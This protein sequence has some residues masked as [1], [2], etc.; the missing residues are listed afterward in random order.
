MHLDPKLGGMDRRG[1]ASTLEDI[2]QPPGTP[3]VRPPPASMG[4]RAA[5]GVAL[6]AASIGVGLPAIAF[7]WIAAV[8]LTTSVTAEALEH[9]GGLEETTFGGGYWLSMGLNVTILLWSVV[10]R[11]RG[12][13]APWKPLALLAVAYLMLIWTA[14][15]PDLAKVVDVP[16]VLTTFALL[17]AD[18]LAS[19]VFP[20]LLLV[21][22]VRGMGHL[23]RIGQ[24]SSLAAQQIGVA[25]TCLG[26]GCMTLAVGL[27]AVDL[28]PK[29]LDVAV[30]EFTD[31]LDVG[32]VKG[33][34][35][36][37]DALS[38]ALGSGLSS[39]GRTGGG[40]SAF[41]H[42][43]EGLAQQQ[44]DSRPVF[45]QATITLIR[46]GL[47]KADAEDVAMDTLIRVCL[48]YAEKGLDNLQLY[49]L[50][51]LRNNA[52]SFR[53]K[54]GYAELW[55]ENL[56]ADPAEV[57]ASERMALEGKLETLLAAQARLSASD[58]RVLQLRYVDGLGYAEI[59]VRLDKGEAAARQQV[60][61][62]RDRLEKAWRREVHRH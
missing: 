39:D 52:N 53:R 5:L 1:T 41:G 56:I 13:P 16:D 21:L 59:G 20:V 49:Y 25:T 31:S 14:V 50:A 8:S 34:L 51:A 37:Y 33:E 7:L 19:Y 10:R 47:S 4:E 48:E 32:G 61:R 26:L 30:E 22:L 17:G 40:Q 9:T 35:Q 62:A 38:L 6:W 57:E 12:R 28:E 36:V 45:E 44:V 55:D 27:A 46:R 18:A 60:K 3:A 24:R 43:A 15:V 11:L 42:C 23:W 29:S 2:S 54:R 58:Q